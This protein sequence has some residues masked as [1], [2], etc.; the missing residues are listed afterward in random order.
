MLLFRDN[1]DHIDICFSLLMT[2]F[3]KQHSEIRYSAM[4]ITDYL[5]DRSTRFRD[6][7]LEDFQSFFEYIFGRRSSNLK[8]F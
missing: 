4:Q 6:L 2:E 5:F 1:D 3:K 8:R 7:L